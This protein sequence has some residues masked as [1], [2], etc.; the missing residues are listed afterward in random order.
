[1]AGD[2]E[3]CLN[4]GMNDYISKPVDPIILAEKI[5][6]WLNRIQ[7]SN[8]ERSTVDQKKWIRKKMKNMSLGPLIQRR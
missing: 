8:L 4:A 5:E 3:K 1:M 6:K 7:P 2:R